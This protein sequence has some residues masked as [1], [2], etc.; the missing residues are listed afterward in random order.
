MKLYCFPVAPNPTRVRLA[1]AE[2]ALGGAAVSIEEVTVSLPEGEQRS[3][4]HR[5]RNPFGTLPVLE[6]DDGSHLIESETILEYLEELYPE[7]PLLGRDP[8]ERARA[9]QLEC[10]AN[11][12]VLGP[13][14]RLIHASN[15]PLG[16][17]PRP[18]VAELYREELPQGLR[19]LDEVL[20]DGRSFLAG[21][22][23]S[24]AD[25]TLAA[26]FQFARFREVEIDPRFTRLAR[27]D[28]GFRERPS[29]KSVLIR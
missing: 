22:R 16:L 21:P 3:E 28:R 12:R 24:L 25:C 7:P 1:L 8:L 17:P 9:R 18:Q 14:A 27:W 2:K 23:V 19:F 5:A 6:L 26:A 15:S 4:V 11:V 29:A 10:I 20:S 13:V